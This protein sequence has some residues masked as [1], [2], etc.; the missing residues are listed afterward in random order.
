MRPGR[1]PGSGPISKRSVDRA[2]TRVTIRWSGADR[3]AP[4]HDRRPP[5][6]PG[7][8]SPGRWG[9]AL[10]AGHDRDPPDGHVV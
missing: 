1:W 7:P 2:H 4:G 3:Q 6:L 8:A 9:V 10:L 5:L